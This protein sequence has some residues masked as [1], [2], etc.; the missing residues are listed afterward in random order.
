VGSGKWTFGT[1]IPVSLLMQ[2]TDQAE[3]F[4]PAVLL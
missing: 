3:I 2:S 4:N 1:M